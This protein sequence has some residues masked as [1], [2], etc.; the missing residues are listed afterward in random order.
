MT[1]DSWTK[2]LVRDK[3]NTAKGIL[4]EPILD[5]RSFSP[6]LRSWSVQVLVYIES[7]EVVTQTH[8]HTY[9][10]QTCYWIKLPASR[11]QSYKEDLGSE[12]TWEFMVLPST[13]WAERPD[14]FSLW[15]EPGEAWWPTPFSEGEV[16]VTGPWEWKGR[17]WNNWLAGNGWEKLLNAGTSRPVFLKVF[18]CEPLVC[19]C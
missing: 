19:A 10:Y 12:A 8:S 1:S 17:K 14:V 13:A 16:C 7:L 18:Q 2:G 15:C 9:T 3:K 6:I 5:A 11:D 4:F